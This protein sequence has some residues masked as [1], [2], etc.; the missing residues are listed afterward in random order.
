M[1]LDAI[2]PHT[3]IA[4]LSIHSYAGDTFENVSRSFVRIMNAVQAHNNTQR[5]AG[6]DMRYDT[7]RYDTMR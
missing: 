6:H 4:V 1:Q 5:Q 7:M 2:P 3:C